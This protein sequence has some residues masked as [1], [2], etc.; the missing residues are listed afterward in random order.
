MKK[1]GRM[2]E[3]RQV[4]RMEGRA[5]RNLEFSGQLNRN[6]DTVIVFDDVGAFAGFEHI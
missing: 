3:E 4:D 6:I 5:R 2:K 1:N